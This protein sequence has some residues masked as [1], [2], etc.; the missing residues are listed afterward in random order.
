MDPRTLRG[1]SLCEALSPKGKTK[2][3]YI[4]CGG[5]RRERMTRILK[6]SGGGGLKKRREHEE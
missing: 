6:T 2:G 4:L 5:K 3:G 1:D